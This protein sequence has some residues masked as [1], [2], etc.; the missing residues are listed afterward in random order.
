MWILK[1]YVMPLEFVSSN[2]IGDEQA[3]ICQFTGTIYWTPS[4]IDLEPDSPVDIETYEL[5]I[6]ISHKNDIRLGQ[7]L[8]MEFIDQELPDD[9]NTIA[10][11]FTKKVAYRRFKVLLEE[12]GQLEAWY[13]FENNAID[14]ELL[15]WC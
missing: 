13:A 3:Y 15:N 11:Y 7:F 2:K 6:A 10:S 4:E 14:E 8:A 9:Y 12:R 5:Y 1:N